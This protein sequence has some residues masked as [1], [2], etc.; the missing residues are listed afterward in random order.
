MTRNIMTH[1]EAREV[2]E[3]LALDALEA[4]ESAVALA[5]VVGCKDCTEALAA[6]RQAA[7]QLAYASLPVPMVPTQSARVRGRLLARASADGVQDASAAHPF[8]RP[9][10]DAR[11]ARTA[12]RRPPLDPMMWG[13]IAA[14]VIAVVSALSALSAQ[15]AR[16]EARA[17]VQVARAQ[18]LSHRAA[19]DSLKA[20]VADRDQL[21]ANL[22]GP[23]VAVMSLA[24][25][26]PRS[27]SARMF[28]DQRHDAWTFVAHNL[29]MPSQGRVY[30]LWLVT[31]SAKIS[32]GMFMPRANG[33]AVVRATYRLDAG[34]LAAVAVTDEPEGGSA[35]PTSSPMLAVTSR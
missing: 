27:P 15:R 11:I 10:G 23:Q 3:L 9:I 6:L 24:A 14:G 19:L 32:A 21:I 35:Q 16:Y 8:V 18:E 17:A 34:A 13:A 33:D 30:Q 5:H 20:I 4:V 2:L 7:E 22:T 28:W 29:R 26:D 12:R 31:P 1:D 25:T